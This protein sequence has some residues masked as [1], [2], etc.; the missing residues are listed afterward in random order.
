[1]KTLREAL[2]D[3][4]PQL[5][6]AIAELNHIELSDASRDAL[7]SHLAAE[8]AR[9]EVA[10]RAWQSLSDAERGVME[11][12]IA[13]GGRIKAF[14]LS[15]DH[16]EIRAFGPVA[17]ARDKPWQSPANV[18]ERLWYLGFL[19]RAFDIVGEFRGEIFFVPAEIL[20]HLPTPE[21]DA[22]SPSLATVAAPDAVSD[23]GDLLMWD[24]FILMAFVARNEPPFVQDTVLGVEELRAVDAQLRA[25]D[26]FA[27]EDTTHAPRLTFLVRLARTAR[28]IRAT[29]D[30]VRLGPY[31]K[32][33]LRGTYQHRRLHLF[34]AWQRERAW[35]EL[36][37]VS[38]LKIEE[39]GWRNDPKRARETVLKFLAQCPMDAWVSLASFIAAIKQRDPDF[40]RPDGDY[41]RWHIRD[42][43]S[44]KW[45]TGF[46]HWNQVEGALIQFMCEGPLCWLGV[47]SIGGKANEPMA[48]RV[49]EFG[50]RAL[51][52]T[53][54]PMREPQSQRFVV[55][56]D[57]DVL[58][59]HDAP[60]YARF[61]LERMAE[62]VRWDHMSTYRLTREAVTRLLRRNVTVDQI[63]AFL[64]RN[65]RAPFPPNVA[66]TVRE[67]ATKYGE[68][69][70]RRGA[71]L[72]TRD[73]NL[74]AELQHHP[75]VK[76]YI[77]DVLS[78]TVALV[79]SE[80][81]E[82]LQAKLQA[83]GYSPKI[84]EPS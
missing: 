56:G 24:M 25:K 69:T 21:A 81:V 19:Q 18:T 16:G 3:H 13:Q 61:Q 64:S 20:A 75:Q 82:E 54:E 22:A 41:D 47:V 60:F 84:E 45:L 35:N 4:P 58:V 77:L 65:A 30:G 44:G 26:S 7:A 55:Q 51:G 31:A 67:W 40:Q 50:A 32:E 10:Q 2:L 71:V 27:G 79:A 17:L 42:A 74:L 62:R 28:L 46:A 14:Q 48:L 39:T 5:L 78:P 38:S 33:W 53:T 43:E 1:M 52:L 6:R 9:A 29:K 15:R 11:K 76:A 73:K 57:F 34:E 66:F 12:I 59:P 49:T 23:H 80:Q 63:L 68:I 72:H 37:H 83:L 36:R 70:L 8:L